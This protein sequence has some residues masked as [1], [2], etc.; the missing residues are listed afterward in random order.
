[1]E[2]IGEYLKYIR[3][4]KNISLKKVSQ[5][6]K[7]S[8]NVLQNI[9]KDNFPDHL[10]NVFLTGHLRVYAKYLNLDSDEIIKN[11]KI[12]HFKEPDIPNEIPRPV[13]K[14]N[15]FYNMKSIS[16]FSVI[17]ISFGFYFLFIKSNDLHPIYSI[18]PNIPEFIEYEVE[19]IEMELALAKEEK[20]LNSNQINDSKK[21]LN[22]ESSAIASLPE[23]KTLEEFDNLITL[24][25]I[26]STWFQ[27]RDENNNI[28]ISKLMSKGLE[29][30]YDINNNY[31]VTT[32]N[33]GNIVVAIDNESR[34]RLGKRGEVVESFIIHTDFN[35]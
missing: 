13:L 19:E 23:E 15:F 9:E 11:F 3:T 10:N 14:N 24:K 4:D 16:F 32:G 30:S 6:L 7:I 26:D 27:I 8:L 21:Y 1:M 18:T 2:R 17:F 33:G 31:K 22:N 20:L 29:F 28:I 35:N 34:G 12:Q 25:F 5:D